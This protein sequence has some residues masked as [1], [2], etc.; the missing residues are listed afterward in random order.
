[1]PSNMSEARSPCAVKG[2]V[3]GRLCACKAIAAARNMATVF[4]RI[5]GFLT[6]GSRICHPGQRRLYI[7]PAQLEALLILSLQPLRRAPAPPS[8]DPS[9]RYPRLSYAENAEPSRPV[10][11][12]QPGWTQIPCWW[13]RAV[14]GAR[15]GLPT[16]GHPIGCLLLTQPSS[17]NRQHARV[18]QTW[19]HKTVTA[20]RL[21][22]YADDPVTTG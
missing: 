13:F 4:I 5:M 17:L 3:P 2:T 20:S 12:L 9:P 10:K 6:T 8:T 16:A 22:S 15:T 21:A 11:L 14:V 18:R 19:V 1:M 7:Q